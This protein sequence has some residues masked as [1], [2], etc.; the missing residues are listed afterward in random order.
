MRCEKCGARIS[1]EQMSYFV[2]I[3]EYKASVQR[4][5]GTYVE[6]SS[7]PT[8]LLTLCEKDVVAFRDWLKAD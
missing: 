1:D 7:L 3:T 5:F 4:C 6:P 2:E 8:R